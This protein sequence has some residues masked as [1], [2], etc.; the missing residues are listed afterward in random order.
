[1]ACAGPN[2]QFRSFP[3]AVDR[4]LQSGR[5]LALGRAWNKFWNDRNFLA[6][7]SETQ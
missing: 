5:C 2:R 6:G 1:M 7:A 3:R 4:A